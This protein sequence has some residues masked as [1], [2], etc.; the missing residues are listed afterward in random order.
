MNVKNITYVPDMM[1]RWPRQSN[2]CL[3]MRNRNLASLVKVQS[4]LLRWVLALKQRELLSYLIPYY[5]V[6]QPRYWNLNI[7]LYDGILLNLLENEISATLEW[8]IVQCLPIFWLSNHSFSCNCYNNWYQDCYIWNHY[9]DNWKCKK[10][11]IPFVVSPTITEK[12]I[13]LQIKGKYSRYSVNR[14]NHIYDMV[15]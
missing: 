8:K 14:E 3:P 15:W 4:G 6:H 10:F 5:S 2:R 9:S 13:S 11:R 12:R 1:K 7:I